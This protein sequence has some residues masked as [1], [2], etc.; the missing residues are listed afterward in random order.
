[1][2]G[3]HNS[4]SILDNQARIQLRIMGA[5]SRQ[6]TIRN[7]ARSNVSINYLHDR[8]YLQR[9]E[10]VPQHPPNRGRTVLESKIPS[11]HRHLIPS[12][13]PSFLPFFLLPSFFPFFRCFQTNHPSYPS[14]SNVSVTQSSSTT[15]KQPSTTCAYT[16]CARKTASCSSPRSRRRRTPARAHT[17]TAGIGIS[18]RVTTLLPLR[19]DLTA[20]RCIWMMSRR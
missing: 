18:R 7:H 12:S 10:R 19:R 9:T 11:R 3:L 4:Q 14:S 8:R 13:F 2:V 6:P 17:E 5:R 20:A 1:M 15:S 16:G